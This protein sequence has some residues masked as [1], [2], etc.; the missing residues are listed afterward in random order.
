MIEN[1][2]LISP[3]LVLVAVAVQV[4]VALGGEKCLLEGKTRPDHNGEI[5]F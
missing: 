4:A 1:K 2:I 5:Y 3:L